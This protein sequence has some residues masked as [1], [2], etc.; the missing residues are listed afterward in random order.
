[1]SKKNENSIAKNPNS[2][3][4]Y[5]E[6]EIDELA[7]CMDDEEGYLYFARNFAYIQHPLHGRVL[8][9]P[10]E[11]QIRLMH[12]YHNYRFNINML[13]RQ[14]GKT[15]C[16]AVYL[17]WRAMFYPDQTILIA[18]HVYK[19][20]QEIMQRI[21]FVYELCPDYIRAG[22]T[23][24]NKESIDFDNGSRIKAETTTENTGRGMSISL[25]YCDE[26]AHVP[27]NIADEFWSSISPTLSTGGSAI[28][29]STPNTD[30]D[31]FAEIWHQAEQHFDEHGN[32]TDIGVNG[33][34]AFYA[35]WSEHPERDLEWMKDEKARIGEE[36][37]RREFECL[38]GA[39]QILVKDQLDNEFYISLNNL[40][41]LLEDQ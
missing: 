26:F 27:P 12:I 13:P 36:R 29:T 19:G 17:L 14:S 5:T 38:S 15:T 16:A 6:K 34:K 40:A 35:H 9:E 41:K 11:F 8:F 7:K 30:E 10:F 18:A 2:K 33:F 25:L 1:M 24:Y 21:R 20:A 37:F 22:T 32:E 39:T 4:E 23:S 31:K 28:I 3:E